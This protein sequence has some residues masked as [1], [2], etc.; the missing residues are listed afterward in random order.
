MTQDTPSR[1]LDK[2]IVR[3]PDGMRDRIREA[4]ENNNR[5]MNAEIVARLDASLNPPP[6]GSLFGLSNT[7]NHDS[8]TKATQ[9][10]MIEFK[11]IS[12][13]NEQNEL[14]TR[15]ILE[16]A[17]ANEGKVPEQLLAKAKEL[18]ETPVLNEPDKDPA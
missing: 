9:D 17:I 1:S 8:L 7:G 3:L 12:L 4:A 2:V 16:A 11:K 6:M 5:S 10:F 18:L 15:L 14:A 13:R